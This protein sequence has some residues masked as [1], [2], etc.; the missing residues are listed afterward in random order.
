MIPVD[1]GTVTT[2]RAL[3]E[4][5]EEL[6]GGF[7]PFIRRTLML[8]LPLWVWLL[9]WSAGMPNIVSALFSGLSLSIIVAIERYKLRQMAGKDN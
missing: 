1:P 3:D 9:M 4:G 8:F 2:I 5:S 6:F 7:W